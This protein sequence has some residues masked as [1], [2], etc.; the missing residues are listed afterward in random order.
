M[1]KVQDGLSLFAT[2]FNFCTLKIN[3]LITEN[4]KSYYI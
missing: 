2:Q 3:K 4:V 1:L